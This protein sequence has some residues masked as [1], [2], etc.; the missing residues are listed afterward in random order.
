MEKRGDNTVTTPATTLGTRLKWCLL[1]ATASAAALPPQAHA[2]GQ[3]ILGEVIVTARKRQESI[4]NVPVIETA[5]PQQQLERMQVSNLNDLQS[6]VPG[7]MLGASTTTNGMQISIRGIGTTS[8]DPSVDQSISLNIDGQQFSQGLA[9]YAGMF[10]VGQVEVL[11]GPQALFYG[12]SSTGGVI[13]LRTAD[14]TGTPEVIARAGYEFEA[15]SKRLELILSGPV[16]DTLK[17]RLAGMYLNSDGFFKNP[18]G[19]GLASTG[20]IPASNRLLGDKMF[21][22]R[23]TALWNP[24]DQFDARFKATFTRD[25]LENGSI[26]QFK[27]CPD[28]S[29]GVPP[30]NIPFIGND[31]CVLDRTFTT[32]GLNPADVRGGLPFGGQS[33]LAMDQGFGTLEMNYR[34]RPDITVTSETGYYLVRTISSFNLSNATYA[35]PP[36]WLVNNYNRRE[37]TEEIRA[38]SEFRGPLNFTVGGFYQNGNVT[39]VIFIPINQVYPFAAFFPPVLVHG[40]TQMRIHSLSLFGQGRYQATPELE[41]ALGA[42]WS[43]EKRSQFV[44]DFNYNFTGTTAVIPMGDPKIES[45]RLSPEL[46]VTYKPTEDVTIFGSLKQG[47][48]SGSFFM[49]GIP[50][51]GQFTAYGD[52]R[53]RGGEL[54]FKSRLLDRRLALDM[55]VYDY[56]Y[57]GLQ[58]GVVQAAAANGI[59]QA[60][61]VNAGKSTA[62]GVELSTSWRP[63]SVAGLTVDFSANYNKGKFNTLNNIPC[64]P[65]QTIAQGCTEQLNLVTGRYTAQNLTGTPLPDGPE[66]QVTGGFVYEYPLGS[67]MSLELSENNNYVSKYL[68]QPGTRPDFYQRGYLKVNASLALRSHNDRWEIA[69][70][71]RN[72]T[73]KI[74]TANCTTANVA[75]GAILGGSVEGA[76]TMGPAGVGEVLCRPDSGREIWVR[77]TYKPVG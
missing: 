77:V 62:K 46:T 1:A 7:L 45:K 13:S 18:A 66:W 38:N 70:I 48:K 52:E 6:M 43:D 4:L 40:S 20:A 33:M 19:T 56:V 60:H 50:S 17:L 9:Y 71:G 67:G 59:P 49:G 5:L 64:T 41:I 68:T 16:T 15:R 57:T 44:T 53:V 30:F 26:G 42:R 2:Q 54:G 51:P 32:V 3:N 28:G 11:K 24:N 72:I 8:E 34:P 73:N 29:G 14:P 31:D 76:T 12:K 27:S 39:H 10:D 21:I 65:G 55:D 36:A 58:V 23:G 47:W 61:T 75:N 25:H 69:L 63:E 74:T 35:A 37:V 22:V